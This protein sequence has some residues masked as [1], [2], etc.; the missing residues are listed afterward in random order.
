[1]R[2][3][4]LEHIARFIFISEIVHFFLFRIL[5]KIIYSKDYTLF[6]DRIFIMHGRI[7][8]FIVLFVVYYKSYIQFYIT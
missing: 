8:S 7:S 4:L 5:I 1:M 3:F 6:W 2:H